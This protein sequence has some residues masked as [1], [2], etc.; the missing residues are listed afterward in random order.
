[1]SFAIESSPG[2]AA[3]AVPFFTQTVG[4]KSLGGQERAAEIRVFGVKLS[5]P[6]SEAA[7]YIFQHRLAGS[8]RRSY[9][10]TPTTPSL[11]TATTGVSRRSGGEFSAEGGL[12]F[13]VIC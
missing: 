3:V 13:T 11:F 2:R 6:S 12:S 9:Q 10:A 7:K 1:M 4:A 5:P 8:S